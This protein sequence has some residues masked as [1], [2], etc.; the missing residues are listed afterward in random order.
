M[1]EPI[2]VL[3][4]LLVNSHLFTSEGM[5][6]PT[7]RL[8]GGTP[9]MGITPPPPRGPYGISFAL[10]GFMRKGPWMMA[11]YLSSSTPSKAILRSGSLVSQGTVHAEASFPDEVSRAPGT[12]A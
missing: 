3:V 6:D 4:E 11:I 1:A 9:T 2:H 10:G 8:D 7:G 5:I 12:A